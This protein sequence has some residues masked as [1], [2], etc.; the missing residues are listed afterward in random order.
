MHW[1]RLQVQ[2]HTQPIHN[3]TH[4]YCSHSPREELGKGGKDGSDEHGSAHTFN[5]SQQHTGQDEQPL[6]T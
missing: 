4:H 1:S 2:Y 6:G 3:I 5:H